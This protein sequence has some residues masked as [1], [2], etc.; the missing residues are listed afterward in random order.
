MKV[1]EKNSG[2]KIDYAVVGTTIVFDD[3]L[4]INC[5]KR[6][7]D[8]PVHE[9]I[10]YDE[11][12]MLVVGAAAGR[13]Y[14]AEIDIPKRE[15]IYPE[16]VDTHSDD[17]ENGGMMEMDPPTPIPLNMDDVTLTLWAIE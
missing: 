12:G 15:Y 17:E 10:C 2:K 7:S 8:S 11:R 5:A 3:D 6:Q 9:D 13:R 1:I 4:S 14:V 16:P